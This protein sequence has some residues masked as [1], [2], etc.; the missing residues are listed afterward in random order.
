MRGQGL[1][2]DQAGQVLARGLGERLARLLVAVPF[3]GR[4]DAVHA[5]AA[6]AARRA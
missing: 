1:A 4:V 3:L 6:L 5:D 2:G